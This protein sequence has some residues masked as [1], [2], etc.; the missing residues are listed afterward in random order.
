MVRVRVVTGK[1]ELVLANKVDEKA[2]IRF[3]W[4]A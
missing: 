4:L 1:E 3:L 2:D